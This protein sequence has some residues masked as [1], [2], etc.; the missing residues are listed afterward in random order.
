MIPLDFG[1]AEN[2]TQIYQLKTPLLSQ[3]DCLATQE[4]S[5]SVE[6]DHP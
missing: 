1:A 5:S 3:L 2:T 6:E 4:W